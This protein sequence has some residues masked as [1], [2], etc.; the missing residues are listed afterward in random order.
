MEEKSN[1]SSE[2]DFA[3]TKRQVSFMYEYWYEN[4]LIDDCFNEEGITYVAEKILEEC[5]QSEDNKGVIID[6]EA[7]QIQTPKYKDDCWNN[8]I[9]DA[10]LGM[11]MKYSTGTTTASFD[12]VKKRIFDFICRWL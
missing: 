5:M 4:D 7:M 2:K 10:N 8:L 12:L 3:F 11:D 1:T 6:L 9:E